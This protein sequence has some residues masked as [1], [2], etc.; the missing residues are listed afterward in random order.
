[1]PKLFFGAEAMVA[2]RVP[3]LT[4]LMS[5][6]SLSSMAKRAM[7]LVVS[8]VMSVPVSTMQTEA[9]RVGAG[10]QVESVALLAAAWE[11]KTS[12]AEA[13]LAR[14]ASAMSVMR[15]ARPRRPGSA[16]PLW[17]VRPDASCALW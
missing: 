7:T 2:M 12:S 10:I 9:R 5:E 6:P 17:L 16:R 14:K 15:A 8:G 3:C 11:V 1:M 13:E 4:G